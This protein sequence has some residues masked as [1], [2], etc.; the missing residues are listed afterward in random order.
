[1]LKQLLAVFMQQEKWYDLYIFRVDPH[2][3]T[4]TKKN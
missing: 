2:I 4:K 3:A 1:M